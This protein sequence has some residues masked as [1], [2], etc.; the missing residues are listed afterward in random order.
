MRRLMCLTFAAV[1]FASLPLSLSWQDSS[2]SSLP[3]VTT[4]KADAWTYR[5]ARVAYRRNWRRAYRHGVY[6]GAI[7]GHY[8][9]YGYPYTAPNYAYRNVY[10]APAGIGWGWGAWHRPHWGPVRGWHWWR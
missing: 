10:A 6:G 3:T 8:G 9:S 2:R 1:I 4:L 7:D 5:R